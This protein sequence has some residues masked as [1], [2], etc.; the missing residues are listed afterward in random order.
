MKTGLNISE[1]VVEGVQILK[2]TGYLDGHTFIELERKLEQL[3]KLGKARLVMDLSGLT[4]IA[5]AGVGAFINGQ[6]QA[7]KNHGSLELANAGP[8]IKEI[9]D[10]LGLDAIF[11]IHTTLNEAVRAAKV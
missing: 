10:I 1:G 3:F 6:H 5:S 7:K 11:T 8:H 4:Y 9:F 2:L